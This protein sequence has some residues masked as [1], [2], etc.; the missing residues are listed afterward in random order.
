M[1]GPESFLGGWIS[2]H[3]KLMILAVLAMFILPLAPSEEVTEVDK[4]L[5]CLTDKKVDIVFVFDTIG[6]MEGEINELSA[7]A[8]NFASDLVASRVDYRLGQVEF[9]DFPKTCGW[10]MKHPLPIEF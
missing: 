7:I 5:D 9:R 2:V 1:L 10:A 8:C 3:Q 4:Y 6:S